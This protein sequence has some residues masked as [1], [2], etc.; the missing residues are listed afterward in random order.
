MCCSTWSRDSYHG[1][2][3]RGGARTKNTTRSKRKRSRHRSKSSAEASQ[4][5]L[6]NS[7][8]TAAR[9]NLNRNLIIA[10]AS[11]SLNPACKDITS[12]G[13]FSITPGSRTDYRKTRNRSRIAC[14]ISS[15][16]G[17]S[18]MS[19]RPPR[20]IQQLRVAWPNRQMP[21]RRT[22]SATLP[23]KKPMPVADSYSK[24]EPRERLQPRNSNSLITNEEVNLK[25]VPSKSSI[26]EERV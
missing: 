20:T 16:N 5:N 25:R 4:V 6:K 23:P 1:K 13:A 26:D 11:P 3:Y 14:W 17:P 2:A 12:M 7:W 15:E 9:L 24:W 10:H 22:K 18:I 8:S 19:S 21:L